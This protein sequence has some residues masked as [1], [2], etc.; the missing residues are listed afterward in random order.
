MLVVTTDAQTTR[1]TSTK[2]ITTKTTSTK[3]TST[4][5]TP[6]TTQIP[7]CV[8]FGHEYIVI[9]FDTLSFVTFNGVYPQKEVIL[10]TK[11]FANDIIIARFGVEITCGE[12]CM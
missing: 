12:V 6:T 9:K 3:T 11:K 1:T 4:T 7:S 2:T 10:R 8:G 5:T